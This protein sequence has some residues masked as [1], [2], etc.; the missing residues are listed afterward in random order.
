MDEMIDEDKISSPQY[1]SSTTKKYEVKGSSTWAG[2]D[3][4]PRNFTSDYKGNYLDPNLHLEE[5]NLWDLRAPPGA[6]TARK[7]KGDQAIEKL[8]RFAK[9]RYGGIKKMFMA[10]SYL[11]NY[12]YIYYIILFYFKFYLNSFE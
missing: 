5:N 2:R 9:V 6:E 8:M 10:V 11:Y 7:A 12:H 4:S 3:I 1:F